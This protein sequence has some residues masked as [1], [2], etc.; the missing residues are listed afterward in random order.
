MSSFVETR[1]ALHR[2]ARFVLAADLEGTTELVTLRVTPGGFGQPERLVDRL[3]RRIRIDGTQLVVQRGENEVWAPITTLAAAAAFASVALPDEA[4]LP[5]DT[6]SIAA[7]D[8]AT[9]A[10]FFASV[11]AALAELRR[12]HPSDEPTIAQLFPHHFDLAIT[13][14]EVNIGGSPGDADHDL[15]YVYV[16]PWNVAPNAL[17]NEPWGASMPWTRATTVQQ[18][19]DFFETGFAAAVHVE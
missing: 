7:P 10:E 8:A 4:P 18:V 2:L 19:I 14:R 6:L 5:D 15:P 11:D 13:M 17:W 1:V 12:R 16:G 9:L 3:Q